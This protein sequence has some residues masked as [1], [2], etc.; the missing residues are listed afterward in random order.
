MADFKV[1]YKITLGHEGGYVNN[2][3]D[4]GQETYKGIARRFHPNW[5]GWEIVDAHKTSSVSETNRILGA[6]IV[7]QEMVERFY[8]AEFWDKLRLDEIRNQSIANE[9][10]DTGVNMGTQR[11]GKFLQEGC[12]LTSRNG[13]DYGLLVIDGAVGP[14]TISTV[15]S[16]PR[17]SNLFNTMN[18][19]Q[20]MHYV[21][22]CRKNPEQQ[23]F[24]NGWLTRVELMK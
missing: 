14:K 2:P 4:R 7:L 5:P 19:L 18:I 9:A 3:L 15:N 11:A 21:E 24:F 8:K 10:F 17:P 6:N 23:T 16:H 1:A 22:D 12:N 13:R 20:G